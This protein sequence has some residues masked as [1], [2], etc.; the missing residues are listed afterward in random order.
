MNYN[1]I[2]RIKNA[3]P[4]TPGIDGINEYKKSGVLI[5]LTMI[6]EQLHFLFQLRC[7]NIRQGGEICFPGGFFDPDLDK[8]IQDTAI[9]ETCE[10]L[11]ISNEMIEI[12]GQ[13]DKIIANMGV[14]VDPFLGFIKINSLDDIQINENEVEKVF[15]LP[16][17]FFIKN[18]PEKYKLKIMVHPEDID[19]NGQEIILFPSKTLELPDV[20]HKH[21]GNFKYD[22]FVYKT[23][24]G[25]IWGITARLIVNA[26]KIL[27][28]L[29]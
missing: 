5:P 11:G 25:V 27:K 16:V 20:Y 9:R 10:E 19:K 21:W 14:T 26:I 28:D 17:D 23:K 4:K 3:I 6:N 13:L 1:E 12:Y 18:E 7:K 22:V 2:D 29:K 24:Y 8:V 15:T